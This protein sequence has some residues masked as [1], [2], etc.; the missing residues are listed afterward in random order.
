[1]FLSIGS[2]R[3]EDVALNFSAVWWI[4]E[5]EESGWEWLSGWIVE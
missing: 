1:M 3:E 5:S 2:A 4:L